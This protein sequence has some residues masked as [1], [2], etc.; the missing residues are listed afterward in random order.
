MMFRTAG[1]SLVFL[2]RADSQFS[3]HQTVASYFVV[4]AHES[5]R[6]APTNESKTANPVKSKEMSE[7]S[8][9]FCGLC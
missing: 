6:N 4:L 5:R 1:E 2:N 8:G 9:T 3:I 7:I